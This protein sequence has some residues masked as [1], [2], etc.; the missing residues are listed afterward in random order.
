M[1]RAQNVDTDFAKAPREGNTASY[2]FNE[3]H[4]GGF[5]FL[6]FFLISALIYLQSHRERNKSKFLC[7]LTQ[8]T[9]ASMDQSIYKYLEYL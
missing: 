5:Q 7:S 4:G 3:F 9:L 8:L 2:I 1:T 6:L